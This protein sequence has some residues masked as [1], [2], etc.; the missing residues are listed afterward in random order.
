LLSD[1]KE[2]PGARSLGL[3]FWPNERFFFNGRAAK[4]GA[5]P[6]GL[7]FLF[8][9]RDFSQNCRACVPSCSPGF[10]RLGS[11][12]VFLGQRTFPWRARKSP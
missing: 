9:E 2:R 7:F 6:P 10:Q 4:A 3:F 1:V 8:F 11:G 5:P 12:P